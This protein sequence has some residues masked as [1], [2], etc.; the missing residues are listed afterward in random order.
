MTAEPAHR[1][2][3][4]AAPAPPASRPSGRHARPLAE[5]H[6]LSLTLDDAAL[7]RARAVLSPAER[8]HADHGVPAVRRRRT[9]L[10]AGMRAA[11]G[12]ALGVA[13]ADVPL[14]ADPLGRPGLGPAA[15]GLDVS[16]S[17]GG[18]LGVVVVGHGVRVGVD[19]EPVAPW[20]A[21]VADEGW[22]TASEL[23]WL[24]LLPPARRAVAATRCWTAKEAVAKAT[25][26]G[27]TGPLPEVGTLRA[28]RT[29]RTAGWLLHPVRVPAGSV[30]TLA[31][32]TPVRLVLDDLP[33]T[34]PPERT[35]R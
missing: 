5:V 31:T 10:R 18:D 26:R 8:E 19:V 34:A 16:C 15:P 7:E 24:R 32:D 25:G 2:G 13:P 3:A 23:R 17:A 22:L 33:T 6:L 21:A 30:A 27:L 11:L 20:T 14:V 1:A 35:T 9:A 28:P 12:S 29:R 4:R